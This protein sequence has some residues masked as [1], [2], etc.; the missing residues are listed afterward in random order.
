MS[1]S[2]SDAFSGSGHEQISTTS[3]PN[4]D[5]IYPSPSH[6]RIR[7]CAASTRP[8]SIPYTASG[9]PVSPYARPATV[10]P[11]SM[12][13]S[14][15]PPPPSAQSAS[16]IVHV[17]ASGA[18]NVLPS[19]VQPLPTLASVPYPPPISTL[20]YSI[21]PASETHPSI[22][23]YPLEL[24]QSQQANTFT[25]YPIHSIQRPATQSSTAVCREESSSSHLGL[26]GG[27]HNVK[28][29]C[30][31]LPGLT[32]LECKDVFLSQ[33]L[34]NGFR[35][36]TLRGMSLREC[37]FDGMSMANLIVGAPAL[38]YLQLTGATGDWQA[39]T[40]FT[41][42]APAH[43]G[44]TLRRLDLDLSSIHMAYHTLTWAHN[45]RIA[46]PIGT[47]RT[48]LT[49][50]TVMAL[51]AVLDICSSSLTELALCIEGPADTMSPDHPS[52]ALG[53][54]SLHALETL[55]LVIHPALLSDVLNNI[56]TASLVKLRRIQLTLIVCNDAEV[57]SGLNELV[58]L[59]RPDRV[60]ALYNFILEIGIN[61]GMSLNGATNNPIVQCVRQKLGA[62]ITFE[63]LATRLTSLKSRFSEETTTRM[64][65]K[66][67]IIKMHEMLLDQMLKR[68]GHFMKI[69][70][71]DSQLA[72]LERLE[73]GSSFNATAL[74]QTSCRATTYAH[75]YPNMASLDSSIEEKVEQD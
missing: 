35:A 55:R 61:E 36:P 37:V 75:A 8:S 46:I 49:A 30:D 4:V 52:V 54:Q 73:G 25:H 57:N 18:Y 64:T 60:P 6:A 24:A 16:P 63:F 20:A 40:S 47:L 62:H 11:Y 51:W 48:W 27:V 28:D 13:P 66:R 23:E 10:S 42:T 67:W 68:Q 29:L 9:P 39:S 38:E 5:T 3:V 19:M 70:V 26:Q 7:R 41:R 15:I 69:T 14:A 43:F 59:W 31:A 71:L 65:T 53:L 72:T 58:L 21:R 12:R 74:Q 33:A 45:T 50:Y 56:A 22:T 34:T 44:L 17:T 32:T 2:H 1:V